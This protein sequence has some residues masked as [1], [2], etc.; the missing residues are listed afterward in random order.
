MEFLIWLTIFVISIAA[1]L[2]AAKWIFVA[3]AG[4]FGRK[5]ARFSLLAGVL[6]ELA[7]ALAALAAGYPEMIVPIAIGSSLATILLVSG[8]CA[9]ATRNLAVKKEYAEIDAPLLTAVLAIFYFCAGDGQIV[10]SEGVFLIVSFFAAVPLIFRSA[11]EEFAP[12][13]LV[14]PGFLFSGRRV[15]QTVAEKFVY[16]ADFT[17]QNMLRSL[18][19]ALISIL[20]LALGADF[21][22]EALVNV[23]GIIALPAALLAV[24]V[25]SVALL[26]PEISRSVR[27]I[28]QNRHEPVLGNVFA[29]ALINIPVCGVAALF[30]PLP[31]GGFIISLGLPCLLAGVA[32]LTMSAFSRKIMTG[33]GWLYLIL[34]GLFLAKLFNLF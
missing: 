16:G 30:S 28:G 21:A 32:A 11:P 12:H 3:A 27:V 20:I 19:L 15:I 7:L 18:F 17:R 22:V 10:S 9:V 4:I 6:P 29:A 13:N 5:S 2:M 26:L 1:V 25:L 31:V 14:S 23:G 33:H 34:Y 8:I 24:S